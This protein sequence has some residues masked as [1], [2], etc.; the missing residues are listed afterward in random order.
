MIAPLKHLSNWHL[1]N[2]FTRTP[3]AERHRD[4]G[5]QDRPRLRKV[6]RQQREV[7]ASYD[8]ASTN[9]FNNRYWRNADGLSA[10]EANSLE[11]RTELR[12]RSRYHCHEA[13]P[14]MQGIVH[15]LANDVIGT[16][17]RLQMLIPGRP[18]LNRELE[19]R[20][21]A[22]AKRIRL[23]KKL[24]LMELAEIV[25][26]EAFAQVVTNRKLQRWL[27]MTLDY[28]VIECDRITTP[29]L[30]YDP[31][32]IDGID[33]D[34]LCEP[35]TYHVLTQHPGSSFYTDETVAVDAS[36]MIH[37]FRQDRPEQHRGVPQTTTAMPVAALRRD[38]LLAVL[39]NAR[40]A[41]KF[42]GVI[43]TGASHLN[44]DNEAFDPDVESFDI[45]DIDYDMLTSLP[46][47][48]KLK[49]YAQRRVVF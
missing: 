16:G 33:L 29:R 9:E 39:H 47:G 26:G 19:Q 27:P 30:R 35:Q 14:I 32:K 5:S 11:V 6:R 42:T 23:A 10:D 46:F 4:L 15:T 45:V 34:E 1:S 13:D 21:H 48:W 44:D 3:A 18:D 22:W 37:A 41:A 43:E 38:Y 20:F 8:A 2:W 17:P 12:N 36:M 7:Q 40:S 49:Q 24:R 28:K 31:Y 25:D